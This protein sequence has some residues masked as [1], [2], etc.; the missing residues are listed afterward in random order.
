[1]AVGPDLSLSISHS[2]L[3][4][5]WR[6][7]W[8]SLVTSTAFQLS[9][10]LQT[11]AF[12]V[13]AVL[14]ST[15]VDDDLFY[16]ILVAL[17]TS[18]AQV[19]E[20]E[21]T[22]VFSMLKC[23]CKAVPS[24]ADNSRYI[25]QIFWLGVALCQCCHVAFHVEACNL[26]R[27]TLENLESRGLLQGGTVP[28]ILLDA[29]A[30][31]EDI[32]SQ[33]DQLL[34]LSFDSSVTFC[35]SAIIFKGVRHSGL[36]EATEAALRTLLQVTLRAAARKEPGAYPNSLHPD[37]LGYFLALLPFS[38]TIASY[39]RLLEDCGAEQRWLPEISPD[40]LDEGH[41]PRL[42][43]D[44]LG[45]H[46]AN[47]ALLVSAFV[48]VMLT[49]AQGNDAE[50]EMLYTFLSDIAE[51]FPETVSMMYVLPSAV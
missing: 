15:E 24:L 50:S 21:T 26:L 16:Q 18:L 11:R 47:T 51:A 31:F 48:A 39:R 27:I 49:T 2:G 32:A 30:P 20:S 46:D 38:T 25:C 36:R 6:A 22:S 4:N 5:V 23:V 3:L 13:L 44:F 7:R 35:L 34:D 19:T 29:R 43:I 33:M 8:M 1:M 41:V 9:P 45:I 28:A 10:A 40:D 17:R 14:A 37:V 42:S 12:V